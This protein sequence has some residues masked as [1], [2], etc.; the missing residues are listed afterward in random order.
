MDSKGVVSI[1]VLSKRIILSLVMLIPGMGLIQAQECELF[2]LEMKSNFY[3]QPRGG[4]IGLYKYIKKNLKYPNS[5]IEK[6]IEGTVVV[7]VILNRACEIITDSLRIAEG[8]HHSLD[9][10]AISVFKNAPKWI[11]Y[12]SSRRPPKCFR[13]LIPVNFDLGD[14]SKNNKSP[15]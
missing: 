9:M 7:E 5:A 15:H 6:E 13:I 1:S 8:V 12:T 10:E 14:V 11:P 2:S 4:E 3:P